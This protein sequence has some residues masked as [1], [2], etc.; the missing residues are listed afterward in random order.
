MFG[1]KFSFAFDETSGGIYN[2]RYRCSASHMSI[3][4]I[5]ESLLENLYR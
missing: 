2:Y 4:R 1:G 3:Y 5:L